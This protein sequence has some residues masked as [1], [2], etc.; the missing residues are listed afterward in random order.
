[1]FLRGRHLTS[2]CSGVL[3]PCN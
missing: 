1:M 3:G 2:G